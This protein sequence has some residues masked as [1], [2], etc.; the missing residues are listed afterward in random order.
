MTRD[1]TQNFTLPQVFFKYFA[2]KNKLP[3]LSVSGTLFENGLGT[4]IYQSKEKCSGP[5]QAYK[6][7][8]LQE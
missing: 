8:V 3:S 4:V 2:S 5:N 1:F 7:N 6:I